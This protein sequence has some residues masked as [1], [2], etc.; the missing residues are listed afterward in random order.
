MPMSDVDNTS[1]ARSRSGPASIRPGNPLQL[2]ALRIA[3]RSCLKWP[4]D[5]SGSARVE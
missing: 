3:S 2:S 1:T 5:A 4:T